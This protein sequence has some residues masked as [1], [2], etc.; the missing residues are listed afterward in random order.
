MLKA[1]E[2]LGFKIRDPNTYGP[3]T[4]GML[5][6]ESRKQGVMFP[7]EKYTRIFQDSVRWTFTSRMGDV[8]RL[9]KGS[10]KKSLKVGIP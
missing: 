4:D 5:M 9:T 6:R 3:V 7:N 8:G 10:S 2:E 1:G